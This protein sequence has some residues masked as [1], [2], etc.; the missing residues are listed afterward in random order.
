V[1]VD[2]IR[3]AQRRLSLRFDAPL[4]LRVL[5]RLHRHRA[6][7]FRRFH[8]YG[9]FIFAL[10]VVA[11]L[12]EGGHRP[13][14]RLQ[15]ARTRNAVAAALHPHQ[16]RDGLSAGFVVVEIHEVAD[17]PLLLLD[18]AFGSVDELAGELD[19]VADVVTGDDDGKERKKKKKP[20]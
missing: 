15:L 12:G 20:I 8:L 9:V 19:S 11:D 16:R 1:D 6:H 10:E 7:E 2:Q 18:D 3:F 14:A 13:P 5:G 4:E 17:V